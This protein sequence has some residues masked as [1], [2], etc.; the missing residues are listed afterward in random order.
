MFRSIL[1]E[2]S[3][4]CFR[5]TTM[6]RVI[7]FII[8]IKLMALKKCKPTFFGIVSHKVNTDNGKLSYGISLF[9]YDVSLTMEVNHV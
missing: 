5:Y 3:V 1:G 4:L 7:G 9:E 8:S 2:F 6:Y